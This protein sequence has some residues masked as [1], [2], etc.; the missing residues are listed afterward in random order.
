MISKT[1]SLEVSGIRRTGVSQAGCGKY[2]TQKA[3]DVS[4]AHPVSEILGDLASDE[5][6]RDR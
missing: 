5:L 1:T 2:K 4:V 3:C 6:P